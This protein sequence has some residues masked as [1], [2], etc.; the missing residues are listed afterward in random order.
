MK[1]KARPQEMKVSE[2]REEKKKQGKIPGGES[3]CNY[4]IHSNLKNIV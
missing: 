1:S 3:F 2:Q 4:L